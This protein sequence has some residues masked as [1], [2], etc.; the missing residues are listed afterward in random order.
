M[1]EV[2][3][4]HQ[5]TEP[6]ITLTPNAIRFLF[7]IRKWAG[8]L[9]IMGFIGVGFIVLAALFMGV[10]FSVLPMGNADMPFPGF[11]FTIIYLVLAVL[12]FFP[13]YYLYQFTTRLKTALL[14]R[15][16]EFL[17]SAFK[18]L[19]SHYKFIGILTIVMLALYPIILIVAVVFGVMSGM[20]NY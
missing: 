18:F 4:T 3:T 11:I 14:Q 12:Y 8:F 2:V 10:I 1:E 15:S 16:D 7:E 6:K 17:E 19:K 9:A 13:V 5:E 20:G